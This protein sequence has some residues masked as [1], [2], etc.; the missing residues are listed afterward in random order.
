MEKVQT[1][2][3]E[4]YSLGFSLPSLILSPLSPPFLFIS[5]F[6]II[7]TSSQN[8]EVIKEL[9]DYL[10]TDEETKPEKSVYS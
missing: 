9:R 4:E 2:T 10:V 7:I 6:N 1:S 8:S 5:E 3:H